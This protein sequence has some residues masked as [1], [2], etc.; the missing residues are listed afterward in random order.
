MNKYKF[1]KKLN[2]F[3]IF[4]IF[5]IIFLGLR[6]IFFEKYNTIHTNIIIDIINVYFFFIRYIVSIYYLFKILI[7]PNNRLNI[8]VKTITDFIIFAIIIY[9]KMVSI[10]GLILSYII[11]FLET[12]ATNF[13]TIPLGVIITMMVK[14]SKKTALNIFI[15][16]VIIGVLILL[17]AINAKIIVTDF[18]YLEDAISLP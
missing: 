12:T 13:I 2:L 16:F 17:F 6:A 8:I 15:K 18:A 1:E 4:N 5:Y 10:Y 3:S 14:L 9:C 11:A 7:N